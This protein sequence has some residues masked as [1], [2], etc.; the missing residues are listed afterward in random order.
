MRKRPV[1]REHELAKA[2]R[3]FVRDALDVPIADYQ[4]FA[5]DSAQKATDNQRARMI[6]RGIVV[7]TP[8]TL[9]CIKQHQPFWC[10]LK[11]G[12]NTTSD[13]QKRLLDKLLVMG[14]HVG[15]T[16]SVVGYCMLLHL[17]RIPLRSSARLIATDLD[18]KVQARIAKAE[19][20]SASPASSHKTTPRFTASKRVTKRWAKAGLRV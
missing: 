15:V 11:W 10:E 20:R 12:N 9:L 1:Q 14:H 13:D 3:I 19:Q 5:F 7:G 2:V 16:R 4:F 17:A 18:L 8:D 6:A